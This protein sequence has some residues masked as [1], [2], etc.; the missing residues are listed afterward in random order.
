MDG[1]AIWQTG[2]GLW[3]SGSPENVEIELKSCLIFQKNIGNT[4][5]KLPYPGTRRGAE[6][7]GRGEGEG[8]CCCRFSLSHLDTRSKTTND[9]QTAT[10]EECV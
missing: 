4:I 8:V 6:K 9:N 7:R 5:P 1:V 3:T 2:K 10:V